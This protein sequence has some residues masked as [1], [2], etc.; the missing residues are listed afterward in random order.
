[1]CTIYDIGTNTKSQ[2]IFTCILKRKEDLVKKYEAQITHVD[3]MVDG[4][5]LRLC[6]S[7]FKHN[8]GAYL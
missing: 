2:K 8:M 5:M 7:R 3:T 6:L 4:M 1:M